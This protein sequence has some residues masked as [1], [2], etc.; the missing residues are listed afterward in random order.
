[1]VTKHNIEWVSLRIS[2]DMRMW[3][4]GGGEPLQTGFFIDKNA[5]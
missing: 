3:A 5:Y 2:Q 4:P 1:M